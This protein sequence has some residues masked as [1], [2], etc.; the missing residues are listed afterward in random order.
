MSK[1]KEI[2]ALEER[3]VELETELKAKKVAPRKPVKPQVQK[4][5]V[6]SR[7]KSA[8]N[9]Y[10]DSNFVKNLTESD[11]ERLTRQERREL[12]YEKRARRNDVKRYRKRQK[13]PSK[14]WIFVKGFFRVL[15]VLIVIALI[16][17]IVAAIGLVIIW[18]LVNFGVVASNA[19]TFIAFCWD[20]LGRIFAL[21]GKAIPVI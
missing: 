19:N 20:L 8:V 1:K 13:G 15:F 18:A 21:F 7:P 9:I 14:L 17:A 10:F 11:E 12:A 2:T 3:I 16:L 6:K 4:A 5:P